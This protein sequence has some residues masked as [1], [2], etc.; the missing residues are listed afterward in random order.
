MRGG[1]WTPPALTVCIVCIVVGFAVGVC[2]SLIYLGRGAA[3]WDDKLDWGAVSNFCGAALNSIVVI[4]AAWAISTYI[5]QKHSGAD[6]ERLL[7]AD[8]ARR[9]L[10]SADKAHE[11]FCRCYSSKNYSDEDRVTFIGLFTAL[12]QDIQL[13]QDTLSMAGLD[14]KAVELAQNFR[15]QYK[16]LV[17]D[18]S[19]G[20]PLTADDTR[21]E[22]IKYTEVR[23]HLVRVILDA[24]R[25]LQ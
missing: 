4:V 20:Q 19:S 1:R 11:N 24:N 8:F 15:S 7:I 2:C 10:A 13:I 23:N 3:K 21:A 16:D 22:V 12:G 5:H 18:H 6:T 14:T 17:T 25:T 9:A